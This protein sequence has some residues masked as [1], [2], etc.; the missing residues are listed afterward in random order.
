MIRIA[1]FAVF[2]FALSAFAAAEKNISCSLAVSQLRGESH[3]SKSGGRSLN[4][5]ATGTGS[6]TVERSLK[7]KV[8]VRFREERPEKTELK[9]Y[10]IGYTDGGKTLAIL[11]D[12]TCPVELDVNG[13][14]TVELNSPKTRLVKT[15]TRTTKGSSGGS[16][17]KTT[18]SGD[19]ISACV[20]QL[21]G[22]GAL[23]KGWASDPRMAELAKKVPFSIE[24]MTR[25]SGKIGQ[26]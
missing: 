8:D 5:R 10:H 11:G 20:V 14:A 9:A 22:D 26:K 24:E 19:R 3:V 1:L 2:A 17:T 4:G 15:R 25:K 18:S 12:E 13:R 16:S 21:F 6:K 7:W 23:L